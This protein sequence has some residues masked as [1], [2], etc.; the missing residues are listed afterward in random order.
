MGKDERKNRMHNWQQ[1]SEIEG[2]K[3][4]KTMFEQ[5][6]TQWNITP[7]CIGNYIG[8]HYGPYYNIPAST[9]R[10]VLHRYGIKMKKKGGSRYKIAHKTLEHYQKIMDLNYENM[11]RSEIC[12]KTGLTQMQFYHTH[13]R[14]P[15][16]YKKYYYWTE[17]MKMERSNK[18]KHAGEGR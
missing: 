8:W 17:E 5:F 11:T 9:I 18:L 14:F 4:S 2:Y 13:K 1:I 12:E 3:D 7:V 10:V 6:Y 15:F 16:K